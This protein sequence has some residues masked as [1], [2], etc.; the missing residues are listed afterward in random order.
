MRTQGVK[1][2]IK[3]LFSDTS[4][5]AQSDS[6]RLAT[7]LLL[8]RLMAGIAL[9]SHGFGKIQA[10]FSWMGPDAPIPGF[11]LFLAALSEFGG[12]LALVLGLLV[13]LASFG[14]IC[15]MAVAA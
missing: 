4:R 8:L 7:A 11:L 14:I 2:M 9:M 13:P 10:P 6:N 12:G 1:H 15:T 3:H 5:I